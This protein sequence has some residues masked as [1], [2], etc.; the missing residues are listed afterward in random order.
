[1]ADYFNEDETAGGTNPPIGVEVRYWA[2]FWLGFF[3]G[4]PIGV[5][6]SWWLR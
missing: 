1:M 2:L 3:I 6:I 5:V 4:F